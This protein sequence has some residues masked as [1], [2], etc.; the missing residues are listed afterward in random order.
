MLKTCSEINDTAPS[1]ETGGRFSFYIKENSLL[2][3]KIAIKYIIISVYDE[4]K[5]GNINENQN[6]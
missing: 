2:F 5:G 1:A 6:S 4:M 3:G